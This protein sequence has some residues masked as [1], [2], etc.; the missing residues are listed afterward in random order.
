METNREERREEIREEK[1]EERREERK[2][3]RLPD[4]N[5]EEVLANGKKQHNHSTKRINKLWIWLGVIILIF[6]LIWWL[7]TIGMAEDETGVT[8]GVS[9]LLGS[10][11]ETIRLS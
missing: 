4:Q 2:E 8:N 9:Q 11:A 1:R 3:Q 7:W 5:A 6:I 10:F